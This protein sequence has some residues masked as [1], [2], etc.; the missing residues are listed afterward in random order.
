MAGGKSCFGLTTPP[1]QIPPWGPYCIE[2]GPHIAVCQNIQGGKEEK[3]KNTLSQNK[4]A[5][6][7]PAN[8]SHV[9]FSIRRSRFSRRPDAGA[10]GAREQ[11]LCHMPAKRSGHSRMRGTSCGGALHIRCASLYPHCPG[12]PSPRP[13]ASSLFMC[14][15]HYH[16]EPPSN[17]PTS[18]HPHRLRWMFCPPFAFC[19]ALMSQGHMCN[20]PKRR[21]SR[22]G[23]LQP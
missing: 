12:H 8:I 9:S 5:T 3:K 22:I 18:P 6:W 14:Q 15:Q 11:R 21:T 4:S 13:I 16:G 2:R 17:P 20:L 7:L 1:P 19:S 23:P 10:A